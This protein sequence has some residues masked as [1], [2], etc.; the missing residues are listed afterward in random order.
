MTKIAVGSLGLC[1][2]LLTDERKMLA[3]AWTG[4][5]FCFAFPLSKVSSMMLL[6]HSC[7]LHPILGD[8]GVRGGGRYKETWGNLEVLHTDAWADCSPGLC[9]GCCRVP[10]GTAPFRAVRCLGLLLLM[11]GFCAQGRAELVFL[12]CTTWSCKVSTRG[13]FSTCLE[14]CSV[15]PLRL[16]WLPQGRL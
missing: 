16:R 6:S 14:S 8:P 2:L 9:R 3:S 11:E 10:V 4:R 7:W 15:P 1:F 5:L 13:A 12:P